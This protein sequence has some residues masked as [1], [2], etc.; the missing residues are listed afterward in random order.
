MFTIKGV[1]LVPGGGGGGGS[2][3]QSLSIGRRSLSDDVPS[4]S[5]FK[6]SFKKRVNSFTANSSTIVMTDVTAR[7]N[8][9]V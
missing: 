9:G 2:A 1:D 3:N 7:Y 8:T 5:K 6:R 4:C